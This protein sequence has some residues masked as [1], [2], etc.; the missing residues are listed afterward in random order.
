[1][2]AYIDIHMYI[3]LY[4]HAYIYIYTS[5]SLSLG[6]IQLNQLVF[7]VGGTAAVGGSTT[8]RTFACHKPRRIVM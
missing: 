3:C 5:L 4:V 2:Y 1:M 6:D 7:V 8:G